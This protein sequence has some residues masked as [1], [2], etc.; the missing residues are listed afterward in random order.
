[1]KPWW[2]AMAGAA[3]VLAQ[4]GFMAA[5]RPLGAVPDLVLVL[6]VLVGLSGTA[7]EALALG[8]AGGLALDLAGGA[9]FGL[10][11]AVLVLAALACALVHR[12]GLATGGPWLAAGIVAVATV[13]HDAA[14][15]ASLA[16]HLT[17]W[18]WHAVAQPV[19]VELVANL[20]IV[21]LLRPLVGIIIPSD[22]ATARAVG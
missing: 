15:L 17:A 3:A 19:A 9:D 2:L 8:L 7:S 14:I 21:V 22:T 10:H 20:V 1:M 18:P 13:V 12:A 11:T 6:V 16:G 5:W 4:V